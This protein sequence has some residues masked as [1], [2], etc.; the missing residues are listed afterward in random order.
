MEGSNDYPTGSRLAIILL[1]L[2][3]GTFLVAIDTTIVSVAIPKISTQFHS[4]DNVGWYGSAY[5]ITITALQPAGGT[6]YK[7]FNP[8]VVYLSAIV[9]FE[10][11]P[12]ARSNHGPCLTFISRISLVCR[13]S[14]FPS[15]H[16]RKSSSRKRC[17]AADSRRHKCHNPDFDLGETPALHWACR[18]LFW[19]IG[20]LQPRSRWC[21]DISSELEMVLLDVSL[22]S[23]HRIDFDR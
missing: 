10:G 21:V 6:I 16:L 1:S 2:F 3:L 9:V 18:Q 22:S 17:C 23:R 15:V 5:L 20:E 7:L 11:K 13:S 19:N 8:K 4:L 12:A 14:K